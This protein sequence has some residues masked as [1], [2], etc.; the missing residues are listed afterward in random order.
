VLLLL[1]QW[2]RLL[3]GGA[4][5]RCRRQVSDIGDVGEFTAEQASVFRYDINP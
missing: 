2:H 1:T 5:V 4:T 3:P